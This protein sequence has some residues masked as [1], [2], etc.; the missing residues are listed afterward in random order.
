MIET[1]REAL[2]ELQLTIQA[3]R[4]RIKTLTAQV[5][6]DDLIS[7]K[8]AMGCIERSIPQWSK[9]K[10]TALF[11]LENLP[12]ALIRRK[13]CKHYQPSKDGD[14]YCKRSVW[15]RIYQYDNDCCNYGERGETDETD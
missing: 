1:Y 7:K 3:L 13:A 4:D 9:D 14:G 2:L 10:E 8:E 5:D 15:A 11:C 6:M 12:S